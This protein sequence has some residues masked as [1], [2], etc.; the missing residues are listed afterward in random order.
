VIVAPIVV[1]GQKG[2]M[3]SD[4]DYSLWVGGLTISR[5]FNANVD[6]IQ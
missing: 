1:G 3:E 2:I 5:Q 6:S 4:S